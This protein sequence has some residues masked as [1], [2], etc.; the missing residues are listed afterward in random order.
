MEKKQHI[1]LNIVIFVIFFIT[2]IFLYAKYVGVKGLIVKEYR[3]VNSTLPSNF[4]GIKIVHISDILYKSTVTKNDIIDVVEKI[5]ILKP[6]IVVFTGDL[7]NKNVKLKED[8]ITFLIKE[9]TDINAT[10][11]K[12]AI[13]GDN[14]FYLDEYE[15]IL[16]ESDF[17]LLNNSYEEIYYKTSENIY[18][19]G[20]PSSINGTI[21]LEDAFEFYDDNNRKWIILLIHDGNTI[22]S[23]D[24]SSYEVDLI[25][26]GHSLNGSVVIPHYGG[27]FIDKYSSKYYGEYY[28]KGITDIYISSGI[29]TDKYKYRFNNRPS[30][31]LYRL[32]A[33]S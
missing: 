29:G 28:K 23:I 22:K 16:E 21:K 10:I 32:K 11:G 6:D 25:L 13:Y 8:D 12:Y 15:R 30:I 31:N 20:I 19:V 7:V 33:Q 14:D 27:L 26:G 2:I 24:N 1:F 18:L 3:V 9:L 4:S 17:I 5:N